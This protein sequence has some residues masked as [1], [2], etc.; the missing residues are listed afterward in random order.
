MARS[1]QARALAR[2]VEGRTVLAVALWTL[3]CLLVAWG[4]RDL[5]STLGEAIAANDSAW[6]TYTVEDYDVLLETGRF[7]DPRKTYQVVGGYDEAAGADVVR[8]RDITLYTQLHDLKVPAAIAV[9]L[10][11]LVVVFL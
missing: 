5:V 1:E 6:A 9:Y 11:G 4:S 7:A 3:L 10:G 8:V 2:R